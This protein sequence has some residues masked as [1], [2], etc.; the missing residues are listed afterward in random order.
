MCTFGD[1]EKTQNIITCELKY[2]N[3]YSISHITYVHFNTC[4]YINFAALLFELL[5]ACYITSD[6]T[7]LLEILMVNLP[8]WDE[9]NPNGNSFKLTSS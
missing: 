9:N 5:Q 4:W 6:P 7:Y 1:E 3:A 2:A 8:Y